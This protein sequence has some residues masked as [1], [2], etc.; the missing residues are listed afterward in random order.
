MRPQVLLIHGFNVSDKGVGSV[1][2]LRGYFAAESFPYHIHKYGHV[3]LLETRFMND[4]IAKDVAEFIENA[5]RPVV[6]VGHSNGCAIIYLA[7]TLYGARP[8]H[9]VFINPALVRDIDLPAHCSYDVWHSPSDRP[10][11]LA[12]WLPRT[13]YRPWGDMG[14]VGA[15][16]K[17]GLDLVNYNKEDNYLVSSNEHS[18]VFHTS[19][20]SYFGPLIVGTV[21]SRISK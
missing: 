3:M 12:R 14:A 7:M 5:D 11:K 2:E 19:K 1:G 10:V 15:N 18:D 8:K 16:P 6:A 17:E 4:N 20:L 21:V 9:C 13:K